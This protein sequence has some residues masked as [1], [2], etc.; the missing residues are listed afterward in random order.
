[1]NDETLH[2]LLV[3]DEEDH[4]ELIRRALNASALEMELSVADS[5]AE[6]RQLLSDNTS[7]FMI[8]DFR[9]PD[10]EGVALLP[11]S[12]EKRTIPIIVLTGHGDEKVAAAAIKAGAMDYIVKSDE[13]LANISHSINRVLREWNHITECKLAREALKESEARYHDMY[14][15]APDMFVS[16]MAE[17]AKIRDCNQ[18]LADN[19]G[20][21]KEEIIDRP[22]FD[23]YHPD[24]MED[25]KKAFHS[26]V[27]TGEVHN[28]ELQLK[29]KDGSKIDVNLN[30]SA[31]RDENGK[32]LYSRSIWRDITERKLAEEKL[33][34]SESRYCSFVSNFQGI[35]FRG[36]MNFVPLFFHGAVEEITGYTEDEFTAGKQ[37]WDQIIHQ[38]D[39]PRVYE[40]A[41]KIR[42]VPNHSCEREYRIIRKDGKERWVYELIQNICDESGKPSFVQGA[43][44]DITKRKK[45]E[46]QLRHERNKLMSVFN[47]MEDG[48]YIVNQQ[49]DIEYINPVLEK[50]YGPWKGRKCYNYFH[51]REEICPWCPNQKVFAGE[52]VHWEWYSCNNKRTYDLI[53]TPLRNADGS[54]SKLEIFRDITERKRNEEELRRSKK[55]FEDIANNTLEWIWEIDI[56][57]KYTYS[58]PVVEKILGYTPDEI[59]K[60]HFFDLFH[61]EDREE[62][63][64]AA[65][66]A[67]AK[68]QPFREFINRNVHKNGQQKLLSTS[69]V[70]IFD[71]RGNLLGYRGADTD[72]TERKQAE[73]TFKALIES[74][75]EKTG[76]EFFDGIVG[77]V[78]GWLGAECAI[79]G[80]IGDDG[81]VWALAMQ[82]DGKHV[83]GHEYDLPGTPCNNVAVKGYC[84]Y[85]ENVCELFPDDRD[86]VEMQAEERECIEKRRI[87]VSLILNR[88][89]EAEEQEVLDY[90]LEECISITRSQ[91]S[92]VGLM[93]EDESVMHV[94]AWSRAVMA[95]CD[96][97]DKILDFPIAKAGI[98]A[99]AVRQRKPVIINDLA[100]SHPQKRGY[101]QGHVEIRRYLGV[102][103]F[104]GERIAALVSVANKAGEYTEHDCGGLG[105]LL[106][107]AWR[108][109]QR[110]RA[111]EKLKQK[112]DEIERMNRLMVGRELKMEELRKEI[113]RLKEEIAALRSQ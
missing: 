74:T 92:F 86:L 110:R 44:H 57:G 1:M 28:A 41:E 71:E 99:E 59:L 7:D 104:E 11:G 31:V 87:E 69:G 101:P 96:V 25:V 14:D 63:K 111:E 53:D 52:T 76:Q 2:I 24:C 97:E 20:Y 34:Q 103:V 109:I 64:K 45:G 81:H 9:L 90:V 3:D 65:F 21:S 47:A 42:S 43:I 10:G 108:L 105:S 58:S 30:V 70:P 60:K 68:K 82:V 78:C 83:P 93:S 102:P 89:I 15:N 6:A 18:T 107:D 95:E 66:K 79:L 38:D 27:T 88:M 106:T 51:D 16:V 113:K 23:M 46:E 5:L 19:L 13:S 112:L 77:S 80:E 61:T 26:F 73:D 32:V 40:E 62:L 100:K 29:R 94:H 4:V 72:I 54:I 49:Y 85:P 36:D 37:R 39:L 91:Y 12:S 35:A 84:E 48:V 56:H 17:T 50:E 22:I 8:V 75:G 98:W 33:S 55:R 67:L